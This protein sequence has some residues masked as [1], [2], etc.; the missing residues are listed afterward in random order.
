[1][2]VDS[3]PLSLA[4]LSMIMVE[5][6]LVSLFFEYAGGFRSLPHLARHL[7]TRATG[8]LLPFVRFAPAGK[9]PERHRRGGT[10]GVGS[11]RAVSK[12]AERGR[13]P[14][15]FRRAQRGANLLARPP[16][17]T[18][19]RRRFDFAGRVGTYARDG[20]SCPWRSAVCAANPGAEFHSGVAGESAGFTNCASDSRGRAANR[21]NSA[22]A[23]C[24]CACA[25]VADDCGHEFAPGSAVCAH[26]TRAAAAA[27]R[28]ADAGA[29]G[30]DRRAVETVAPEWSDSV[31]HCADRA[32]IGLFAAE[33]CD[34]LWVGLHPGDAVAATA[35]SAA[36]AAHGFAAASA[37]GVGYG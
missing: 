19:L 25:H 4:Y 29:A 1:M 6:T 12:F 5:G 13:L 23:K 37:P 31:R 24:R 28:R 11:R 10:A 15:T 14:A 22:A 36:N 18:G 32:T 8:Q 2:V 16:A 34:G 26:A 7:A 17:E 9:R 21:W 3:G 20:S 35:I 27:T 33:Q 30:E